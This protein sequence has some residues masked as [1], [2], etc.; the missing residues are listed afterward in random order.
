MKDIQNKIIALFRSLVEMVESMALTEIKAFKAENPQIINDPEFGIML[1]HKEALYHFRLH[2]NEKAL[3]IYNSILERNLKNPDNHSIGVTN[4]GILKVLMAMGR[5]DDV[6]I[7]AKRILKEYDFD[8]SINREILHE[9]ILCDSKVDLEAFKDKIIE[10]EEE[11]MIDLDQ[12]LDLKNR[13]LFM[14]EENRRA[15]LAFTEIIMETP[16]ETMKEKLIEF[17]A[18]EKVIFY[19]NQAENYLNSLS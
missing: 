16:K 19:K 5:N 3:Q 8:S 13:L 7:L 4:L 14:W 9:M 6:G 15:N 12:T 18:E 2:E 1:L 11:M 10:I 17:I